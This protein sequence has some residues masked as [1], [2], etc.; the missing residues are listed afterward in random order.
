MV[1]NGEDTYVI[2]V[3]YFMKD[4]KKKYLDSTVNVNCR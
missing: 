1:H 3:P 2:S 4:K